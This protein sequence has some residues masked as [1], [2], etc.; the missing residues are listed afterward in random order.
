M[1]A[2]AKPIIS[3]PISATWS[4]NGR[5]RAMNSAIS[6]SAG[7][8]CLWM[9]TRISIRC[10]GFAEV[11]DPAD[12][13]V[14]CAL[15]PGR[16]SRAGSARL[17]RSG[18]RPSSA[19]CRRRPRRRRSRSRRSVARSRA[20]GRRPRAAGCG[21]GAAARSA[22]RRR[23][24]GSPPVKPMLGVDGRQQADQ[25]DARSSSSQSSS[26]SFGGCEHIRQ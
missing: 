15:A 7:A 6:G 17:R 25:L 10:A 18:C 1:L 19:D 2:R 12:R 14:E 13:L 8:V 4:T 16:R 9:T 21:R 11:D 23:C 5:L 26:R 3:R 22:A 20:R 24:V